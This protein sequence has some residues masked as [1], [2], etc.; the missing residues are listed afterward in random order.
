MMEKMRNKRKKGFTLIELIVVI[1]IL[2]ILALLA[3][4]R[5]AGTQT[6]AQ[7]RTHNA[8]VRTIESAVSLAQAESGDAITSFDAINDL[9]TDGYLQEVPTNPLPAGHAQ[10]GAYS[11]TDGVVSPGMVP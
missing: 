9:V 4:P 2:A 7:E 11:I 8:N 10:A 6:R 1:A 3:I 5:F